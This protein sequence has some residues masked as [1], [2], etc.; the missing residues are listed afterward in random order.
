MR[1]PAIRILR[2]R[3]PDLA[4]L[5]M[6]NWEREGLLVVYRHGHREGFVIVAVRPRW[7][8]ISTLV[9]WWAGW[10]SKR[11]LRCEQCHRAVKA[12]GLFSVEGPEGLMVCAVCATSQLDTEPPPSPRITRSFFMDFGSRQGGGR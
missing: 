7:R 9:F 3:Y 6:R 12:N 4:A 8:W 5:L 11:P 10:P 2:T 1:L